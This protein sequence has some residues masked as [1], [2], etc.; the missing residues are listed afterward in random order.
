MN[1]FSE[2]LAIFGIAVIGLVLVLLG[3]LSYRLGRVTR[4]QAY[5][6]WFYVAAVFVEIGVAARILNFSGRLASIDGL[7]D[8]IGWVLLY[9]GAPAF[10]VTVGTVVAWRYW[11][12]LLAERG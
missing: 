9:F 10:G 4:A 5:Y 2:L 7:N 1:A 6:R 8:N 12:W 3:I 11:S